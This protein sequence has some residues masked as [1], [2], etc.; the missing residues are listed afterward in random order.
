LVSATIQTAKST[1]KIGP[2]TKCWR[3]I[4]R[5]GVWPRPIVLSSYKASKPFA[6]FYAPYSGLAIISIAGLLLAP[7]VHRVMH[8]FHTKSG[9]QE[10]IR[11]APGVEPVP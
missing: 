1:G 3:R 8:K 9:R 5:S 11:N 4:G 6:S 7:I 2:E 10:R